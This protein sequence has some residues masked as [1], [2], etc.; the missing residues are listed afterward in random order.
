MISPH[1]R[2]RKAREYAGLSQ[3]ELAEKVG[4]SQQHMSRIESKKVKQFDTALFAK[5]LKVAEEWIAFG[6]NPPS[7]INFATEGEYN[8]EAIEKIAH[9]IQIT[10]DAFVT[11]NPK[12]S[13]SAKLE[14][15]ANAPTLT[16]AKALRVSLLE[17]V[18]TSDELRKLIDSDT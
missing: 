6:K 4:I 15:L 2:V 3:G 7:W 10:L 12:I 5:E 13:D 17:N 11:T 9:A 8:L 14:L 18:K 16:M 1:D